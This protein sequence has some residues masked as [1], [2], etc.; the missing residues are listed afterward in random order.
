MNNSDQINCILD[1]YDKECE[2]FQDHIDKIKK[3]RH[4]S[5]AFNSSNKENYRGMNS[6]KSQMS[7][8]PTGAFT[9]KKLGGG[10]ST[11]ELSH[12]QT[13]EAI[14]SPKII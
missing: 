4:P 7:I 11:V 9:E 14:C 1:T 3:Q 2:V 6:G 5:E 13:T 8:S 10:T 12:I